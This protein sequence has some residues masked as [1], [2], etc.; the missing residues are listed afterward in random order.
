MSVI[1]SLDAAF[2]S[3][4]KSIS[5]N[6]MWT[7]LV[8]AEA[9]AEMRKR[10]F[11][12]TGLTCSCGI[13]PNRMLAKICSDMNKP[14]G[15]YAINADPEEIKQFMASLDIRKIPGIGKVN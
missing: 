11:E 9:A 14:N 15:Q 2:V 6:M 12:N 8:G 7:S 3:Q 10:V 13:A 5:S 4:V 1:E